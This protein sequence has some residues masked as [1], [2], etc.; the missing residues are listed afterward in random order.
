[1]TKIEALLIEALTKKEHQTPAKQVL[2]SVEQQLADAI[3]R[4]KASKAETMQSCTIYGCVSLDKRQSHDALI[5]PLDITIVPLN[6]ANANKQ[7]IKASEKDNI[8]NTAN[9]MPLRARY[10]N[11]RLYGHASASSVGYIRDTY[12]D[13]GNVIKAAAFIWRSFNP[14]LCEYIEDV[15]T[16][17]T[18]WEILYDSAEVDSAGVSWLNGC[19]VQAVCLVDQ[20]AYGK[21]TPVQVRY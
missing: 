14:D 6:V 3:A 17:Y 10:E 19:I 4:V 2:N 20:P 15:G 16:L 12:M 1:M 11:D 8:L 18:S 9:G 13:T 7:G 21:L 5:L